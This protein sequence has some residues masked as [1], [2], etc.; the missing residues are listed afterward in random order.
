VHRRESATPAVD[1]RA[2]VAD[3]TA[4]DDDTLARTAA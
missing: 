1:D 4:A 2:L 3:F